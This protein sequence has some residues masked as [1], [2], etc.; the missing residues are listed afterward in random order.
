MARLFLFLTFIGIAHAQL[1]P[2]TTSPLT[3]GANPQSLA[4][5][6]FN[7]DGKI[8]LATANSGSNSVTI[9]LNAGNNTFT[10]TASS[11]IAVGT[12]PQSLAAA[13]FNGDGKPDL[14]VA[15]AG[16]N[17]VTVLLWNG[18][19]ST[20]AVGTAPVFVVAA[21]FN[22]DGKPDIATANSGDNTVTILLNNGN[23][24][25]TAAPGSPVS[26]GALPQALAAADL[27]A[28]GKIDL[29]VANTADNTVTV[30]LGN[31]AGGFIPEPGSPFPTGNGPDY[32]V[33]RDVNGDGHP[34]I[35]TANSNDGTVTVMSASG[36]SPYT[37]TVGAKPAF[38]AFPDLNNDGSPDLVA[39]NSAANT[40]SILY[41][42]GAGTFT[43]A[44]ASPIATGSKPFGAALADF[45]GDGRP[46]LA[47]A[48][49]AD[50]TVTLL[51]NSL[52]AVVA[53]PQS[54]TFNGAAAIPVSIAAATSGATYTAAS[55]QPWLVPTPASNATGGTSNTTLT[56][57]P[58][59][60]AP[61][62]YTATVRFTAP[63]WY[64]AAVDATLNVSAASGTLQPATN[65]PFPAGVTP[66]N[67]AIA[68]LNLDGNLDLA[69][70]D[71][72]ANTVT[73]LLG[74]G[75]GNFIPAPNSPFA[76]GN[77]PASVAI[78]D[79]NRDGHPDLAIANTTDKTVTVLLGDGTG[80]F[81]P[82]AG[83][84]YPTGKSPLTVSTADLN[85]DGFPDLVTA[86]SGDKTLTILLGNGTGGF[87]PAPASPLSLGLAP[88]AAALGDFNGDGIPDVA[89]VAFPA[90]ITVLFGD[91]FGGFSGAKAFTAGSF[92]VALAIA[93]LNA[94]GKLDI[95]AANSGSNNLTVLLGN[96]A[97]GFAAAPGSPFA[98]GGTPQSVA[99]ADLNG[100]GKPD[101]IAANAFDS[102][103]TVLLGN[104]SGGFT[105]ASGSPFPAG[106]TPYSVAA[107][108]FNADGRADLAIAD[109]A[110]SAVTILL[111]AQ[112]ATAAGLTTTASTTAS[113]PFGTSIPL[114][115]KLTQPNGGFNAPTGTVTILDGGTSIGKAAQTSSPYTF[116]AASLQPGVH[117]LTASYSGDAAN[118]A[119]TSSPIAINMTAAAQTIT[120]G[121][122]ANKPFGTASISLT[123]T[124]SS[125]LPVTFA[126]TTPAVCT[127]TGTAVTL[128]SVGT[129]SIQATQP[130]S[131]NFAPA[132]PVTQSFTVTQGSQT[133]TF[134]A[135]G[136]AAVGSGP[137]SLTATAS[138]GL[139]VAFASTTAP[140]CTVSGTSVTPV[141][142]GTCTIQATQPGNAN[143]A[144]APSVSQHFTVTP[145]SQTIT[146]APL[147]DQIFG[148][149][150]FTVSAT[151]SSGLT[152]TFTSA[153]APVC[154]VSGAT[155]T[156]VSVG[157]CT[158]NAAQPGNTSFGA[159]PQV[160]QSF[161]VTQG[162][163]IITFNSLQDKV[164]GS[165]H[166]NVTATSSSGLT[167][168]FAS[169][170][171]T[172]CTVASGSVT[173]VSVGSCTVE[174]SQ[175]G[176]NNYLAAPVVD[177]TFNVTPAS[178]TITF[179]SL[180]NKTFGAAAITVSATAS[181]SLTVAFASTTPTVCTVMGTSVTLIGAGTC[182]VEASQP[183]NTNYAAATPVD[184]SF[185][186]AQGAQTITFAA[187]S[188]V[189]YGS[190]PVTIT[191]TAS[192][193]LT[194][195]F[196]STTT[197]ICTVSGTTVT[198]VAVGTCT[199][200]ATQPGNANYNAATSVN[201][202]FTVTPEPQ[203]ITFGTLA[204][205]PFGS[206]PFKLSVAASS[207]LAVTLTSGT[208]PVCTVSANTV[209]LVGLGTCTLTAAQPGNSIYAAATSVS[210][211]FTVTQGTQTITFNQPPSV[212]IGAAPFT[213]TATASSGLAVTLASTTPTV[214]KV[215]GATVTILTQGACTITA[216]QP[217]NTTWA[218]ATPVSQT[219]NIGP[220][221]T[222]ASVL[223]AASY[224][225]TP[226]AADGYTV[227][228]GANI[229]ASAADTPSTTLPTSLG[230]VTVTVTD[231]NGLVET[232][233]LFYV[234]AS[235]VNFL[236]PEGLA[237]GAATV[238]VIGTDG[239]KA[240]FPTKIAP[241]APALFTADASGKGVAAAILLE[242]GAQGPAV[243]N[244][245]GTTPTCAAVPI[246]LSTP[247]GPVYLILFGTGIRGRS[248]LA[249]VTL[250]AGGKTLP[251][252]YAGAQGTFPGLDQI[253]VLLDPTLAGK[254]PLTLQLT[255]D[256]SPANPVTLTVK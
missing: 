126:S 104:G 97:G 205:L 16:S 231:S 227:I 90:G 175:A 33:I 140:V 55:T 26:V 210:Q 218:A 82:A 60:L 19:H 188:N 170:T 12:N 182:T 252:S 99:I 169:I 103:A 225:A 157:L 13:D 86:N 125:T 8:D 153:T 232:A 57:T 112:A 63:N 77:A 40:V 128:L 176:N 11:P 67:V 244:C 45:N 149:A 113:L 94:D 73:V 186:V 189:P 239:S 165:P 66:Q 200:Q 234:S 101:L 81:T 197:S 226:L 100:D 162:G 132:N 233:P 211:S 83:S 2:P 36:A 204:N 187:L 168:S 122:L 212:A 22:G 240:T 35:A 173:L 5:A 74:D 172:V 193:M 1:T 21:D 10:P 114:T 203:T 241:I 61:G 221:V 111:G 164:F 242:S 220:A 14:V 185:T 146:F 102:T 131:A 228:F 18:A 223:N 62:V 49:S 59:A 253:N 183:G 37:V 117:T 207:G 174:A 52:H 215:A 152:V 91:G 166:F 98:V 141:A 24:A 230:G 39:V 147:M 68:D 177:Q 58:G 130:G 133:I 158:V 181:S 163:Q 92:P 15:N 150:T 247:A 178:Q 64:D 42:N 127:V 196:A 129:C 136:N 224:L 50:S 23:G 31:G 209:T 236:V 199:I 65:S 251:V 85:R 6:D 27:N 237:T 69:I 202:S 76:T 48:N 120:F 46:D 219:F 7:G 28:D 121:S 116:T 47:I 89:T 115:V 41:G 110:A 255:I 75:A 155:V 32:V 139:T 70:A 17:S 38:L 190:Q 161:H 159:A 109:V 201:Q 142:T 78:G 4:A 123:A 54:L 107:G 195:A 171:P 143:Y 180:T 151:A 248:S 194:V 167:V 254:G 20:F 30:L 206:P 106:S 245:T 87:A 43:A 72:A 184:Q 250:T 256:G 80:N 222:L 192:S 238:T 95:A 53:T 217:G 179:G 119:S 191:A 124:A 235:Q 145:M 84:P 198:I 246:D 214:C 154:T 29:A 229:A 243:F 138:S 44:P 96:G 3:T 105:P 135:P 148:T 25:F 9:L 34:D 134:T 56:A 208:A 160:A 118:S 71:N 249:G 108:D 144:A 213:L 156:L 51:L 137:I 216:T 88:Q 79:F 93:D